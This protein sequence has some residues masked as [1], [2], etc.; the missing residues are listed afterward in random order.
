MVRFME[1]EN[2]SNWYLIF[3][4]PWARY[5]SYIR[6]ITTITVAF[7]VA[8]IIHVSYHHPSDKIMIEHDLAEIDDN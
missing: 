3:N 7:R 4:K 2:P 5:A 1:A 8:W 6:S